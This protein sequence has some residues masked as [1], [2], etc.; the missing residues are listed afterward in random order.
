MA[1]EQLHIA[2]VPWLAFG[3][4]MPWLE[5]AKLIAQKGHKISFISTPRNI[6]RLPKTPPHLS[7]AIHFIKVPL[8]QIEGLPPDAEATS[9]LPSNKV[10]YLKK[11]LDLLQEPLTQLLAS[12]DPDWVFSDFATYWVGSIAA[13][14]GIKTVCFSICIAAL[15]GFLGPSSVLIDGG[16]FE[17]PED[18]TAPPK[19]V[20]F[21]TTVAYRYFDIKNTFDLVEGDVSGVNDP[22]RFGWWFRSCDVI[23]AR[24][25]SEFEPEWLRLLETNHG[26]PVFPVGQL[27]P[28]E[29]ETQDQADDDTWGSTKE[30]LDLH[31]KGTVVYVAFGSEAKPSQTQL[32][33]LALGVELSGLPFFWVLKTR[34]GSTDTELI[35]LPP[36][37]E[38]RTKGRGVIWRGWVPQLKILAHDSVGGFLT[39]SGWSSVVEALM[40]ERALIIF[41]FYADQGINASLLE[42]KKIGY[43]IPRNELDG[44][45]TRDSVAE[46]LKLVMVS[47]EGKIYRDKAKEMKPLFSDR[48]RQ[49]NYVDNFLSYLKTHKPAAKGTQQQEITNS[50]SWGGVALFDQHVK[51]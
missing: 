5:L 46:S 29:N 9:D 49:A 17:K 47:E 3:H 30:W 38:E 39:H 44:S 33:E 14:L 48:I 21:P 41:T 12:L 50:S 25:C 34:R 32:T 31:E 22:I 1:D 45:F 10:Q 13:K 8:P 27:P 28:T 43:R 23:A 40:F 2:M 6:D 37:F 7:S 19:W 16:Y 15:L 36:G 26:K 20:N 35:E 18:F 4:M 11:A 42:E 51:E 24:S